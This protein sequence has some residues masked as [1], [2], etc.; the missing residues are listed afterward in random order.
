LINN[1]GII[2]NGRTCR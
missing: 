2:N 1:G